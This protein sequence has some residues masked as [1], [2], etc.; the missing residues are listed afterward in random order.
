MLDE[1]D[2]RRCPAQG[3]ARYVK[4]VLG[5]GPSILDTMKEVADGL[6]G[7]DKTLTLKVIEDIRRELNSDRRPSNGAQLTPAKK[8]KPD[9][10]S[11]QQSRDNECPRRT[12]EGDA[13]PRTGVEVRTK[14][15]QKADQDRIVKCTTDEFWQMYELEAHMLGVDLNHNKCKNY[16]F[17]GRYAEIISV[18]SPNKIQYQ[19]HCCISCRDSKGFA[20]FAMG[21]AVECTALCGKLGAMYTAR[22]L[23]Q[24]GKEIVPRRLEIKMRRDHQAH[25]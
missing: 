3:R 1:L 19:S 6:T 25:G 14:P 18:R 24:Q 13:E 17:C 5:S 4:D 23:A 15:F 7:Q 16:E 20:D 8:Q 22:G 10:D 9:S 2:N 12:I 11:R 21:H